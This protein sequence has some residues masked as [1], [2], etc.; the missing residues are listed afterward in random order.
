MFADRGSRWVALVLVLVF[1]LSA[2]GLYALGFRDEPLIRLVLTV[3]AGFGFGL[4]LFRNLFVDRIDNVLVVTLAVE[5]LALFTVG[6]GSLVHV[7]FGTG[8]LIVGFGAIIVGAGI[9]AGAT[10][11]LA[12][13][14]LWSGWAGA[15]AA[16]IMALTGIVL[17][18]IG[19]III[20]QGDRKIP[21][22]PGIG[23]AGAVLLLMQALMLL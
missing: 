20:P 5:Y 7:L 13:L 4:A 2:A 8:A 3:N 10:K 9:G 16:L 1:L 23:A 14:F 18:V 21:L 17:T 19:R 6:A 22:G 15:T 11:L 12:A